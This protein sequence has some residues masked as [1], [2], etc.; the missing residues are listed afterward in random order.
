MLQQRVEQVAGHRVH[1]IDQDAVERGLAV[2]KLDIGRLQPLQQ[3][4]LLCQRLRRSAQRPEQPLERRLIKRSGVVV[5]AIA[6]VHGITCPFPPGP[7]R[8]AGAAQPDRRLGRAPFRWRPSRALAIWLWTSDRRRAFSAWASSCAFWRIASASRRAS[9]SI[10]ARDLL[11]CLGRLADDLLRLALRLG[12]VPVVVL[13][14]PWPRP[15][16]PRP[17]PPCSWRCGP[18]ARP[19][20]AEW[21][22]T[23]GPST[24]R[25]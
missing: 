1:A 14:R 4:R 11:A 18:G 20:R 6:G 8:P 22:Y 25:P 2:G 16:A 7:G 10:S 15:R 3:G 17:R 24:A 21:V 13:L 19:A 23:A 12:D 9:A 5:R